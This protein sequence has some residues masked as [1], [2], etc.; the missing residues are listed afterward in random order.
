MPS[1]IAAK[2]IPWSA[3]WRRPERRHGPTSAGTLPISQSK[4]M[5]KYT[6]SDA[7]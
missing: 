2:A 5:P 6:Q 3:T 1:P 4:V 7:E